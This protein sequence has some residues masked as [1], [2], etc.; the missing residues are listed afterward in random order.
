M[1]CKIESAIDFSF[2]YDLD[3]DHHS[4]IGRPSIDP[5][6]L[7][8]FPLI[9]YTFVIRSMRKT[10]EEVQTNMEDRWFF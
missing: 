10:I 5:V 3:Q 8:K 1:V 6:I 2:I 7:I 9:R 4:E